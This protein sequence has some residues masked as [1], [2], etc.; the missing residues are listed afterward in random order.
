[1]SVYLLRP[2]FDLA[3]ANDCF[4]WFLIALSELNYNYDVFIF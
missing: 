2:I 4:I 1:M 3:A